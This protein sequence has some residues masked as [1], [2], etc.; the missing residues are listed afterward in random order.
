[1]QSSSDW[2]SIMD[3]LRGIADGAETPLHN[4]IMLNARHELAAWGRAYRDQDRATRSPGRWLWPI[5][6]Y[7]EFYQQN[8]PTCSRDILSEHVDT[9]TSAY[10]SDALSNGSPVAAHSWNMSTVCTR[11]LPLRHDRHR[12]KDFVEKKLHP[13]ILLEIHPHFGDSQDNQ[14]PIHHFIVTEPGVLMMSGMNIQGLSVVLD[15]ILSSVDRVLLPSDI[16]MVLVARKILT[17]CKRVEDAIEML[18]RYQYGS[19]SS[20]LLSQSSRDELQEHT[21]PWG[22][23]E[24]ELQH[25]DGSGCNLEVFPSSLDGQ[26]RFKEIKPGHDEIHEQFLVHTN[27][28]LSRDEFQVSELAQN[29]TLRPVNFTYRA[30]DSRTRHDRLHFL[31]ETHTGFIYREDIFEFFC[32]H[33]NEPGSLCQHTKKDSYPSLSEASGHFDGSWRRPSNN[34]T[35]CFVAYHLNERKITVSTGP[36][37]E[38]N[39]LVFYLPEAGQEY[40]EQH[41]GNDKAFREPPKK[42]Q[43]KPPTPPNPETDPKKRET[44]PKRHLDPQVHLP[45]SSKIAQQDQQ[46]DPDLAQAVLW[47]DRDNRKMQETLHLGLR[48][49]NATHVGFDDLTRA[50]LQL[51]GSSANQ[52]QPASVET[53]EEEKKRQQEQEQRRLNGLRVLEEIW[54][55][56]DRVKMLAQGK[57][58]GDDD[59]DDTEIIGTPP[60]AEGNDRKLCKWT[61]YEEAEFTDHSLAVKAANFLGFDSAEARLRSRVMAKLRSIDFMLGRGSTWLRNQRTW[62]NEVGSDVEHVEYIGVAG[63]H[64]AESEFEYDEDPTHWG[65][66][67]VCYDIQTGRKFRFPWGHPLRNLAPLRIIPYSHTQHRKLMKQKKRY[68]GLWK[69]RQKTKI[70]NLR[71]EARRLQKEEEERARKRAAYQRKLQEKEEEEKRRKKEEEENRSFSGPVPRRKYTEKEERRRKNRKKNKVKYSK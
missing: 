24:F 5:Q 9:S 36:L 58:V 63:P 66:Y 59:W 64:G 57:I 39:T 8:K 31:I 6:D 11:S 7:H 35:V 42:T 27:H 54:R 62:K 29:P 20:L 33:T 13:A 41:L 16:P 46:I 56:P 3:E 22:D 4:I 40:A 1:M 68:H 45:A 70:E 43:I 53:S 34:K 55:I 17:C 14:V 12:H 52:S 69:L 49:R 47:R 2:T 19:S 28:T 38:G 26:L 32:N 44:P 61:I 37:C 15:T 10:V 71:R 50:Q 48:T 25:V 23:T 67:R 21:S 30:A 60:R 65:K 51:S 18:R